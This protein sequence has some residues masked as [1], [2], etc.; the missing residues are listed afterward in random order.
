MKITKTHL[1]EYG[2]IYDIFYENGYDECLVDMGDEILKKF[3]DITAAF[4]QAR[5]DYLSSDRE[6]AAYAVW[7]MKYHK[8]IERSKAA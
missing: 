8:A 2:K 6:V 7:F 5:K 1:K 4:L 3:P